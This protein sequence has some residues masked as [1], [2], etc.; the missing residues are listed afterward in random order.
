MTRAQYRAVL[1]DGRARG[2]D[3]RPGAERDHGSGRD[4]A[5]WVARGYEG[6]ALS[7]CNTWTATPPEV[8]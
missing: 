2:D 6:R 4:Y 5:G 3:R 1:A 8:S 7:F